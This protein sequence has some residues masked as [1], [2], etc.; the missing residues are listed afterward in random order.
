MVDGNVTIRTRRD[1]Y[2]GL[3]DDTL[4]GGAKSTLT[5]WHPA[6]KLPA[7][8]AYL[9]VVRIIATTNLPEKQKLPRL[10]VEA[11][12]RSR[13]G[14]LSAIDKPLLTFYGFM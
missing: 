1:S 2:P 7:D 14:F 6:I 8:A 10:V 9:L 12:W 11:Q 3:N 13:H 4:D 5:S